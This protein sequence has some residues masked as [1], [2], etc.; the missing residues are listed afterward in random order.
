VD[1]H[2]QCRKQR[3][4][5]SQ[6][7][8]K[9]AIGWGRRTAS[10][11]A[12]VSQRSGCSRRKVCTRNESMFK[13]WRCSPQLK[14]VVMLQALSGIKRQLRYLT[15]SRSGQLHFVASVIPGPSDGMTRDSVCFLVRSTVLLVSQNNAASLSNLFCKELFVEAEMTTSSDCAVHRHVE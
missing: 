2:D 13:R 8:D 5:S 11:L 1:P 6:A 3:Q 12:A 7:L 9:N 4:T 10:Y 14:S 15:S